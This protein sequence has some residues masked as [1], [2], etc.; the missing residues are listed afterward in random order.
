MKLEEAKKM[1]ADNEH[2]ENKTFKQKEI[3]ALIILQK[4]ADL[5]SIAQGAQRYILGGNTLPTSAHQEYEL[6]LLFDLQDWLSAQ[7]P[8]DWMLF[9]EYL[10]RV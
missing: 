1:L 3:S 8:L 9:S 5:L 6:Y 10:R 2:L 7:R 4:D